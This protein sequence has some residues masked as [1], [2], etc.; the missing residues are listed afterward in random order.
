MVGS[1]NRHLSLNNVRYQSINKS[2]NC[3]NN[4]NVQTSTI[5]TTVPS[6]LFKLSS[7]DHRI[8][9]N[10]LNNANNNVVISQI[11]ELTPKQFFLNDKV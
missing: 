2:I 7:D 8:H 1:V 5:V 3:N 6:N 4:K 9:S 11:K 10:H